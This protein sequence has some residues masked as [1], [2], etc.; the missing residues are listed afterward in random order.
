MT[1]W[2][3]NE[4]EAELGD[5]AVYYAEH[6]STAIAVAFLDEFARVIE[7]L[8]ANQQLGTRKEGDLRLYP[9]RRFPYSI[10]YGQDEAG[11]PQVYAVAHQNR[12]PGY[13]RARSDRHE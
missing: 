13:W 8:E 10:V 1:Y 5:A 9:L 3:H 11:G 12:E 6:A 4:A 7:L 2:L